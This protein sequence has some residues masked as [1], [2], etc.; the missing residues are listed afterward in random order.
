VQRILNN[1]F[2][3]WVLAPVA[4]LWA[5]G[6][7]YIQINYPTCTFRYK[8]TAE[9][10]TPEGVKSG[11]S[12]V[13]VSYTTQSAPLSQGG[14]FDSVLGEATYVDLGDGKNLFV[15]LGTLDSAQPVQHW[16]SPNMSSPLIEPSEY[17]KMNGALDPIWLPIKIFKLGRTPG[18]EREMCL[19]V[20]KL[21]DQ[22]AEAIALDNLPTLVSFSDLDQPL[23][24]KAVNPTNLPMAFG[25]EYS[26]SAKIQITNE[27][28][29]QVIDSVIPWARTDDRK[30]LYDEVGREIN[31]LTRQWFYKTNQNLERSYLAN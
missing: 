3:K 1:W 17:K 16:Y 7:G 8:L 15:T 25:E 23:T 18:N 5:L 6:W 31:R 27:D 29:T 4:V 13:E 26:L 30:A 9:V 24:A 19:R 28:V 14:R 21:Y 2:V 12:V 10:M 22:P 11:S 20:A